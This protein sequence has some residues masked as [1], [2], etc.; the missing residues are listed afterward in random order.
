[1]KIVASSGYNER[2]FREKFGNR[3][4]GFLQK[5]YT[6]SQVAQAVSHALA[7]SAASA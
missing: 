2:E 1:V 4:D 5:P 6:A 7:G 3:V